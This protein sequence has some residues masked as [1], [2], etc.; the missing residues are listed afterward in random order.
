MSIQH[1][2]GIGLIRDLDL[3]GPK[4]HSL[5]SCHLRAQKSLDFQGPP[6]LKCPSLWIVPPQNHFVPHHINNRYIDSYFTASPLWS[7]NKFKSGQK[8]SDSLGKDIFRA[9]RTSLSDSDRIRSF[10]ILMLM[11]GNSHLISFFFLLFVKNFFMV[12]DYSE[13]SAI[14][15]VRQRIEFL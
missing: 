5:R 7:F 6:P 1:R 9:K 2:V 13:L 14:G 11:N 3:F 8:D 12:D 15:S 10:N 4:W